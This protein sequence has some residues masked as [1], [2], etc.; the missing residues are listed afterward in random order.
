MSARKLYA[1]FP[2]PL[3]LGA[4]AL[5]AAV[6]LSTIQ[7][8]AAGASI[9]HGTVELIADKQSIAP[10]HTLNLGLRFTL[11]KGWHIYWMNPGDSGEPPRVKW[12][13]PQGITA[14]A[15]EWPAPHR[16]GT[17]TIVDYG[18]EDAVTLIVP[19]RASANAATGSANIGAEL[20]VLVCREM[21]IPGKAQV[22]L[23]LPVETKAPESNA[24][25]MEIFAAARKRLP[26]PA[27]PTWKFCVATTKDSFVL[28]VN[29]GHQITEATFFPRAESQISNAT[30]IL[31]P[32]HNG[33]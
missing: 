30:Q 18:Y 29:L 22:S 26:Q 4:V 5:L 23:T 14:G 25:N 16:L 13:L 12:D 27:P 15:I 24:H 1:Q 11:E 19:L 2:L 20:K 6:L 9:P 10:G 17:T 32:T 28:S 7:L 31:T 3:I 21:C 33:F 8:Q